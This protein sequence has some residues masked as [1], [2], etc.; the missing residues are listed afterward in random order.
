MLIAQIVDI[1][2]DRWRTCGAHAELVESGHNVSCGRKRVVGLVTC[3]RERAALLGRAAGDETE[4]S[5]I[6]SWYPRQ[7]SNLRP[8]A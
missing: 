8:T 1:H 4:V 6:T 2:Q 7:D 5:S 3:R